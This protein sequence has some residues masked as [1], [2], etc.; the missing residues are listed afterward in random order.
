MWLARLC[1]MGGLLVGCASGSASVA[2]GD[3]AQPRVDAAAQPHDARVVT[4]SDAPKS[5]DAPVST[6]DATPVDAAPTSDAALFCSGNVD[7]TAAGTCC[8]TLGQPPG[9]CVPGTVT[10]GVCLPSN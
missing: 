4:P 5:V 10:I 8:F 1:L 7:C 2:G 3:D 9:F 6:P